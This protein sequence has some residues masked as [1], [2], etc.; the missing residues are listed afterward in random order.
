MSG[1]P[2]DPGFTFS[3][4]YDVTRWLELPRP[5]SGIDVRTWARDAARAWGEDT[6]RDKRWAK[7]LRAQLESVAGG[8]F[9]EEPDA[10][11]AHV[12][13]PAGAAASL[14]GVLLRLLPP[15]EP[16]DALVRSLVEDAAADAVEPPTSDDVVLSTGVPAH[17]VTIH[18]RADGGSI[19]SMVH[20]VWQ[21]D[22]LVVA[23]LT[24][25]S[26]DIGRL[27][28]AR[29]DHVALAGAVTIHRTDGARTR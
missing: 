16:P 13:C 9:R 21:P 7:N 27:L 5:G 29:D 24:A 8:R 4:D 3:V 15:E 18:E 1:T 6:G 11:Y 17:V 10:V 14:Q 25:G 22:D 12:L 28:M 2:F 26:Y 23:A 19:L 20:V